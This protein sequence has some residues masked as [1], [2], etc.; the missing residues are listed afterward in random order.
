MSY[1]V[2]NSIPLPVYADNTVSKKVFATGATVY[3]GPQGVTTSS[4]TG[5]LTNGQNVTISSTT[6]FVSNGA[7]SIEIVPVTPNPLGS[8]TTIAA[9]NLGATYTLPATG[10]QEVWA[11]ATLTANTTITINGLA[12][13]CRF[14]L[15]L[16]QDATGGRTVTI[17]DG[18][19]T[20]PVTMSPTGLTIISGYSPDGATVNFN[21]E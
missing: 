1:Q 8:V 6:Y 4:Y 11:T 14:R 18:T 2:P 7:A 5:T 15:F 12:A 20:V 3:Y 21:V 19:N 13:G 9:G 17:T 16:I 10:L